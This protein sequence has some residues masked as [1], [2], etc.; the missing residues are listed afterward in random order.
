[1]QGGISVASGLR[2]R[3]KPS[4]R[5]K[6]RLLTV[7]ADYGG[8]R[9][10]EVEVLPL[11]VVPLDDVGRFPIFMVNLE[12]DATTIRLPHPMPPNQDSIADFCEHDASDPPLISMSPAPRALG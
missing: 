8:G 5:T 10:R 2:H 11:A 12:N 4:S 3:S 1:M 7:A 9:S 6:S